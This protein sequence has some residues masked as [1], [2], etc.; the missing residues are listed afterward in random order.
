VLSVGVMRR[1]RQPRDTLITLAALA[2][3]VLVFF[4]LL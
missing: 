2:A 4:A 1:R 3:G